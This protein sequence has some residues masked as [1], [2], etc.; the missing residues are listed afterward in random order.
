MFLQRMEIMHTDKIHC[1]YILLYIAIAISIS[2]GSFWQESVHSQSTSGAQSIIQTLLQGRAILTLQAFAGKC[3][4]AH[5]L[6]G[7]CFCAKMSKVYCLLETSRETCSHHLL[8]CPLFCCFFSCRTRS[9]QNES[10]KES[11][12]NLLKF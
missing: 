10:I 12:R 5:F 9:A 11:L 3:M 7:H 4:V 8:P 1:P 6:N 2:P